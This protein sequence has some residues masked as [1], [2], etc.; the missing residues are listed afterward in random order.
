MAMN[1]DS[2]VQI[3][4]P[5]IAIILVVYALGLW[6]A[7]QFLSALYGYF[8]HDSQHPYTVMAHLIGLDSPLKTISQLSYFDGGIELIITFLS[9]FLIY[10]G[11]AG[12]ALLG[13]V[14]LGNWIGG[15]K[16]Q[17]QPAA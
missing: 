17:G 4:K 12:C 15:T 2:K 7:L 9:Q 10:I 13:A 3:S 5:R 14:A 8:A 1:N 6:V 11:L 16:L